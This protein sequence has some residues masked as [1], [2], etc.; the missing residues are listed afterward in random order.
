MKSLSID[1]KKGRKSG[2]ALGED[3]K[4]NNCRKEKAM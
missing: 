1:E 3:K 2:D 4:K